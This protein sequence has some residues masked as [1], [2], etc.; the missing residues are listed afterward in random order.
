MLA[1]WAAARAGPRRQR[2]RAALLLRLMSVG[3]GT[4]PITPQ[5]QGHGRPAAH[6]L[7]T[8]GDL[9]IQVD[10]T[11]RCVVYCTILYYTVLYCTILY[12]TVLLSAG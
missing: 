2:R 10:H 12:Y 9:A 5:L 11:M 8:C 4:I 7:A 3:A 1:G 6:T